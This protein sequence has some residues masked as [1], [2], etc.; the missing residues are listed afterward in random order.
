[1]LPEFVRDV[2]QFTNRDKVS[3]HSPSNAPAHVYIFVFDRGK[4]G[5]A[6]PD[7]VACAVSRCALA[8]SCLHRRD[9]TTLQL[10]LANEICLVSNKLRLRLCL[11]GLCLLQFGLKP[12]WLM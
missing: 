3:R 4:L 6:V 11:G 9:S 8:S 2:S 1:M 5:M 10:L 7:T 12:Q